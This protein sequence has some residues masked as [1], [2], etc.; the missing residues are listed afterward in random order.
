MVSV[1]GAAVRCSH[2]S[3][4]PPRTVALRDDSVETV[5]RRVDIA[6]VI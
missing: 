2:P 3:T 6:V 1:Y 5:W 4:C